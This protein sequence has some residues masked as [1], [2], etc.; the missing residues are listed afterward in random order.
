LDDIP[1]GQTGTQGPDRSH[2]GSTSINGPAWPEHVL[3]EQGTTYKIDHP[4]AIP[5]EKCLRSYGDEQ[6]IGTLRNHA[7]QK[8][9]NDA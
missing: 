2:I 6:R 3:R 9:Q 8:D 4:S 5:A 1:C 7:V